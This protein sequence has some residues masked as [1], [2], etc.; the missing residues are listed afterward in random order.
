VYVGDFALDTQSA[1]LFQD[2]EKIRLPEQPFQILRLLVARRDEVITRDELRQQLWPADTFVDFDRG[3]NSAI[4]KLR[5]ALGDSAEQPTY[6]ETIPKRGYRLI[7]PVRETEAAPKAQQRKPWLWIAAAIA[8]I[9]VAAI[10][11][12]RFRAGST[13]QIRSIAVLPLTNLSGDPTQEYFSDGMTEALITDLAQLQEVRVISRTSVMRFKNTKESLPEIAKE[14]NV[15]G[16]VEGGVVRSGQRVRVTVQ[17]IRAATDQHI[18]AHGFER[19]ISDVITLQRDLSSA[20]SASIHTE[21]MPHARA[22]RVDPN[23]YDFFLRGTVALGKETA[24]GVN[25]AIAYFE[26]AVAAQPDFAP[27]YAMLAN[28]YSQLTFSGTVAP[29]ESMTRAKRAAL[30]AISLDPD[31][32]QGH[33][34]L[35]RVLFQYDWNWPESEREIRRALALN[36]NDAQTH[37]A[38]STLLRLLHREGEA[39]AESKLIHAIDPLTAKTAGA[40]LGRGIGY[41]TND[42]YPQAIAEISK[43]VQMDP[44]LPRGHFQLGWTLAEA[45]QLNEGI[46]ELER[47]VQLSPNNARFRA[48]LAWAYAISGDE[49]KARAILADLEKRAAHSWIS[50]SS[51]ALVHVGLHQN[52]QA[53]DLLEKAY[54][55]RDF[56]LLSASGRSLK[57]LKS[58]PRFREIIRKIGLPEA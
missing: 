2:G 4:K 22:Q 6:I 54:R 33:R 58:E 1:E 42:D 26:K 48:R 34:E 37:V 23:A 45:G 35:G 12:W 38:L 50:P 13:P 24:G 43:A 5:D 30:K 15:D 18:W 19:D 56:D 7:A 40:F 11:V 10:A 14:L 53:L 44:T 41:R 51:M 28:A 25:E 36:P 52:Q 49:A 3:L 8:I 9:A 32:A 46:A 21:L 55:E 31:L 39:K 17:L 29:S 16:V 47:S 20:I 27:G 57:P